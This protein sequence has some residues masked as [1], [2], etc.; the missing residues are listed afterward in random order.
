MS[1]QFQIVFKYLSVLSFCSDSSHLQIFRHLENLP[2]IAGFS[3]VP[4]H[5]G[6]VWVFVGQCSLLCSFQGSL[7]IVFLLVCSFQCFPWCSL[8]C[9]LWQPA[10]DCG[11]V[12]RGAEWGGVWRSGEEWGGRRQEVNTLPLFSLCPSFQKR[13]GSNFYYLL[14]ACIYI[15][16]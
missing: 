2:K 5:L 10:G 7:N 6:T 8:W 14:F 12:G 1:F 4:S 16:Y 3:C 9:F 15:I 13:T 11:R